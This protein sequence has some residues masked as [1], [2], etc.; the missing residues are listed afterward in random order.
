MEAPAERDRLIEQDGSRVALAGVG[1][2]TWQNPDFLPELWLIDRNAPWEISVTG[3]P[4]TRVVWPA[5][6]GAFTY[7]VIRGSTEL[8]SEQASSASVGPVQCVE[9]DSPD[10]DTL[11]FEDT[12]EPGPGAAFFYLVRSHDGAT[13][14]DYG[15][16][17]SGKPRV[18]A[19]SDCA[20]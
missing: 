3:R 4:G 7:D 5:R 19:S 17:S 14:S 9:D 18:P 2:Y 11:G 8:I 10:L 12:A 6:A 15:L 16:A 20:P 1:N 13:D